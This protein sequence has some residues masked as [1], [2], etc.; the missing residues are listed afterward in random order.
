MQRVG[1]LTAA[2]AVCVARS[3]A[4]AAQFVVFDDF[5]IKTSP[6]PIVRTSPEATLQYNNTVPEELPPV[7]PYYLTYNRWLSSQLVSQQNPGTDR[8]TIDMP[9]TGPSR[10]TSASTA[11]AAGAMRLT[12]VNAYDLVPEGTID[13]PYII[14]DNASVLLVKLD[15]I[16]IPAGGALSLDLT[17]DEALLGRSTYQNVLT[18]SGSTELSFQL[19]TD[20]ELGGLAVFQIEL[21]FRATPDTSFNVSRIGL[22]PEP[23]TLA[24]IGMPLICCSRR[25][26]VR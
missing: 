10:L 9:S 12:Y 20:N 11:G 19:P 1:I 23:S 14:I 21:T 6:L 5:S 7:P 8:I 2:I 26:R 17:F 22:V 3:S 16:Q 25:S 4:L 18:A 15:G 24:I 13:L